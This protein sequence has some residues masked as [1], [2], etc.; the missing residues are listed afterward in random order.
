MPYMTEWVPNKLFL[1]FNG[2]RIF[3]TYRDDEGIIRT[4]WFGTASDTRDVDDDTSF[5]VRDLPTW[6]SHRQS[7]Q[8]ACSTNNSGTQEEDSIRVT[9]IAAI[10]A[11]SLDQYI[12]AAEERPKEIQDTSANCFVSLSLDDESWKINIDCNSSTKR[13]SI[14]ITGGQKAE[15]EDAGIPQ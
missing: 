9:I 1:E 5:D 3:H 11:G 7:L 6:K 13:V 15:L 8:E 10:E 4:Y 12:K 14:P 2:V